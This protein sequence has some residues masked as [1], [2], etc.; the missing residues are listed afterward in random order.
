MTNK[1]LVLVTCGS[2]REARRIGKTL[3]ELKLIA[4][5]NLISAPVDSV[6]RW[7]G[8]V[9]SAKEFLL[10][11]KTTQRRFA[12]VQAEV[13]RLHSYEVPEIIAVPIATGLPAYLSWI[14]ESTSARKRP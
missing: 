13:K 2:A 6:Y 11:L 14:D 5:A 7:K 9:E 1:I 4:C 10:I 8:K 12:S 3:V